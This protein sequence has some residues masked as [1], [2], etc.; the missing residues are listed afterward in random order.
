MGDVFAGLL[1]AEARRGK[2]FCGIRKLQR[3]EGAADT[4]HG[5]KIGFGKHFGHHA[6]FFFAHAV[7]TGDGASCGEAKFENFHRKCESG[8][9]LAGNAAVVENEWMEIAVASMKNVGNAQGVFFAEPRDLAHH[10]RKSSA[11]N[12]AVLNDVVGR[13]TAHCSERGFAAF[14]DEC[15]LG[16]GLGDANFP[17]A[18]RTANFVNVREKG[19]DFG[20]RA[21]KLDEKQAATVG[22]VGVDGG[23]GGLDG[24]MVH[25]FNGGGEHAGGDDTAD[26]GAGFVGGRKRGEE[27]ADAFGALD[28]AENDFRRYAERAFGANE[29]ASE[30]VAGSIERFSAEM[31]ERAVG[32]NDFE[33]DDVGGGEAVL[34]AM[35]AAGVFRDVASDAADGLRRRIGRVEIFVGLDAAGDV[36]IDDAGFDGNASV[37][38]VHFENAVHASKAEDYPVFDWECA[39]AEAGAGTARD[40]R[41]FFAVAETQ[42]GLNL[43]GG[44][45]KQD[46]ARED[47]KIRE[48]IAFVGVAFFE[49]RDETAITDDGTKFVED[50][51]VHEGSLPHSIRESEDVRFFERFAPSE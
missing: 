3:I 18:I 25:H 32:K 45:R 44:G 43:L 8:F 9:F 7:F 21:I 22:I 11:G 5:G 33:A 12:H 29:D 4:L 14:P 20:E 19:L 15:A 6:L 35:R 48:A 26:C 41:K 34:Q 10:S 40:E 49:R 51:G 47:A 27:R 50:G 17:G 37:G 1:A 16:V 46:G 30:I 2:N 36:E 38:N 24:E 28:D 42:D 13:N 31:N 23:F 39:A